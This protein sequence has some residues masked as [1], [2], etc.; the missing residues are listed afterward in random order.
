MFLISCTIGPEMNENDWFLKGLFLIS[1]T[2]HSCH[3]FLTLGGYVKVLAWS[4]EC[5]FYGMKWIK[6]TTDWPVLC[7]GGNWEGLSCH[8]LP[9]TYLLRV[10]SF[11]SCNLLAL[12]LSLCMTGDDWYGL[13]GP[14]FSHEVNC[15]GPG[16]EVV[17]SCTGLTRIGDAMKGNG[18]GLLCLHGRLLCFCPWSYCFKW[19]LITSFSVKSSSWMWK[20][21]VLSSSHMSSSSGCGVWRMYLRF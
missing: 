1:C 21:S 12:V 4:D 16:S 18:A 15:L 19:C 6:V 7:M 17:F 2:A 5:Y 10:L 9:Y 8:W 3:L 13:L 11:S 20:I 14:L